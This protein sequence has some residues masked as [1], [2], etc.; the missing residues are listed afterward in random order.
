MNDGA[1][2]GTTDQAR[3]LLLALRAGPEE[4]FRLVHDPDPLVVRNLLKN[5]HLNEDHLL[6]L[7]KR[8]DLGE[9]LLKALHQRFREGASHRLILAMARNPDLPAAI[10]LS[11][12]PHLY[13]FELL[14]FCLLPGMTPDQRLAA[15]RQIIRRL[16]E[17]PLGQKIT[18]ARRGTNAILAELVKEGHP[19]IVGPCLDN[20]RL[21]EVAL[22]QFLR[23]GAATAETISQIARHPRW[24]HRP[25]LKMAILK[26]PRTPMVWYVCWLPALKGTQLKEL[27]HSRNIPAEKRQRIRDLLNRRG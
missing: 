13:L 12:L 21:K 11:L 26:H 23:T 7:L 14:D 9:D 10:A 22:L 27:L 24:Q 4:L 15:E 1:L 5:P 17:I 16:P 25:N 3:R 19:Q 6:V 18:L 8:R 20:P 2:P